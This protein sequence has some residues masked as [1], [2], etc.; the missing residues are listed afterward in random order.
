M[1][2]YRSSALHMG[3]DPKNRARSLSEVSFDL[4]LCQ[5]GTSKTPFRKVL[6]TCADG[7]ILKQSPVI[8]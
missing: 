4:R 6:Q 2:G 8:S 5:K 7:K 1:A 3:T